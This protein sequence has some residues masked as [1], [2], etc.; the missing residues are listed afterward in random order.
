MEEVTGTAFLQR[1][2]IC[3]ILTDINMW[4]ILDT[5]MCVNI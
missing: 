3:H 5:L 1:K 2:K 4:H